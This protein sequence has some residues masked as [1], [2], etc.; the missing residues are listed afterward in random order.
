MPAD[1]NFYEWLG[2]P[3]ETYEY[4]LNELEKLV[5]KYITDCNSGN[6][7]KLQNRAS[8]YG[9]DMRNAIAD[10]N[11][12]KKQ[13]T[14]YQK[15]IITKI[16]NAIEMCAE[17]QEISSNNIEQISKNNH[18]SKQY[19][20][21]IAKGKGYKII[22]ISSGNI[23]NIKRQKY[24]FNDIAPESK[25]ILITPQKL[26][27]ELGYRDIA[28][29][30]FHGQQSIDSCKLDELISQLETLKK[31]WKNVSASGSKAQQKGNYD[32]ICS[33]MISFFKQHSI[34]E[35]IDF[36]LWNNVK[37][38]LDDT[39]SELKA[40]NQNSLNKKIFNTKVD[41]IYELVGDKEKALGILESYCDD[42]GIGYPKELPNVA[43]CPFCMNDFEKTAAI[44]ERCPSC[45]SSFLVEC[46]K[47][48]S[49]KN[50]L[51]DD[52]CCG[53]DIHAYPLMLKKLDEANEMLKSLSMEAAK[54]KINEVNAKWPGFPGL[55]EIQKEYSRLSAFYE[56]DIKTLQD[57]YKNNEFVKA[58]GICDKIGGTYP[59]FKASHIYVYNQVE[60][61]ERLFKEYGA[62]NNVDEKI[63]LL[64]DITSEIS[65]FTQA[66]TELKKYPIENITNLE[67]KVDN[68][69]GEV[70][71][72]WESGNRTNSVNYIVRRSAN[73]QVANTAYGEEL[74]S[75]N[76]LAYKDTEI[77]EGTFYYYGVYAQRG[78]MVSKLSFMQAPVIYLKKVDISIHAVSESVSIIWNTTNSKIK[79]FYSENPITSYGMGNECSVVTPSGCDIEGLENGKNYYFAV[80]T[81]AAKDGIEYHSEASFGEATPMVEVACPEITKS[82]GAQDG[83]Y[84]ITHI[85][86]E[87]NLDIQFYHSAAKIRAFE[88]STVSF[89]EL[90]S[91]LQ[92]YSF[93]CIGENKYSLIF[94]NSSIDYLYPVVIR[95]NVATIGNILSLR[96]I[97]SIKILS[98][99]IS[100]NDICITIEEWPQ[101]AESLQ[102]C[103]SNDAYPQD[104]KDC[105]IRLPAISK[106]Q[107]EQEK[108][109]II[110]NVKTQPYYISIFAK[111]NA[112]SI[113]VSNC[114]INNSTPV[115]IEYSL[116]T[117]MFG[118]IKITLNNSSET[119]PELY[120]CVNLLSA[121]LTRE[122]GVLIYTIPASDKVKKKEVFSVPNYT[123]KK[124]EYGKLFFSDK[125]CELLVT[126]G[127]QL[128]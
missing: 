2:L 69:F 31:K 57:C 82:L 101:G 95:E 102:I 34:G 46:P 6:N 20:I 98:T 127:L 113:P 42:K 14:E 1:N 24:S 85:N 45:N 12:W 84:I 30:V 96:Y 23:N 53:I 22:N 89:S 16:S 68:E 52:K 103:Y 121:P 83:E 106:K 47:C 63:N 80:Y 105:D 19:V 125:K 35:Y 120:F 37:K 28:E 36:L 114:Y 59:K 100:A 78:S 15:K 122:E 21:D 18:T 99:I 74:V 117:N 126:G 92:K 32:K 5:E 112:D 104:I 71:I 49:T 65:D 3:V 110:R 90:Q 51:V 86:K 4:N 116:S 97:K 41:A 81:V 91:K 29:L 60:N 33:G 79:V 108:M 17:N 27:E 10:P 70:N 119:R 56:A 40:L 109:L 26:I 50:I 61:A 64:L 66:N 123:A 77:V 25:N 75:T 72:N 39:Q 8:L 55:A 88:N 124:G 38:L 87:D 48:H 9:N 107:Y 7:T 13:Y 11:E 62:K 76:S 54:V 115:K 73:S 128:K 58:K 93:A 43:V 94:K 67:A 44:Q 118:A 111:I